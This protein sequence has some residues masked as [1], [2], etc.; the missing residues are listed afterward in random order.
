MQQRPEIQAMQNEVTA[1]EKFGR[2]EHDLWW[3]TVNAS[4]VVG[5]APARDD[6]IPSWYGGV[7]GENKNSPLYRLPFFFRRQKTP[8]RKEKKSKKEEE[9]EKKQAPA[10]VS[11]LL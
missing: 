9:N 11:L 1:A 10:G 5:Q 8:P 2:A 3:P 6:R 4:G 7:G